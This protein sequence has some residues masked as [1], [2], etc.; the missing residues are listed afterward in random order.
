VL[1]V[2][3]LTDDHE[4]VTEARNAVGGTTASRGHLRKHGEPDGRSGH[5]EQ[6]SNAHPRI[7]AAQARRRRGRLRCERRSVSSSASAA[8]APRATVVSG[9]PS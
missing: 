7:L 2:G 5:C 9:S 3:V 6:D 1:V 4:H 8:P